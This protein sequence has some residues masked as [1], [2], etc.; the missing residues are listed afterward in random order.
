MIEGFCVKKICVNDGL[1]VDVNVLQLM[2]CMVCYSNP[3]FPTI[4]WKHNKK[5]QG[6]QGKS[7]FLRIAHDTCH[8]YVGLQLIF[9]YF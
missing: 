2:C 7:F 5:S 9:L 3:M 1:K 8:P 6:H 4:G